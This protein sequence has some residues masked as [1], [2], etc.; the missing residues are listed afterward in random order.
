MT[1][2]V[3]LPLLVELDASTGMRRITTQGHVFLEQLLEADF[4][5]FL[6]LVAI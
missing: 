5:V 3:L 2:V 1:V 4:H 6:R